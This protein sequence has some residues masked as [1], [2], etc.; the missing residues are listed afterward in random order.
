MKMRKRKS[1][2]KFG[3]FKFYI[4]TL[5]PRNLPKLVNTLIGL[6]NHTHVRDR[7]LILNLPLSVCIQ[8]ILAL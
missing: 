8:M 2:K 1:N 5:S 4:A 6:A 3:F 7:E